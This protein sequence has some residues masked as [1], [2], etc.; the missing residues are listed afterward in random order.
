MKT[1]LLLFAFTV[2]L[3]SLRA[4]GDAPAVPQYAITDL[5]LLQAPKYGSVEMGA[6]ALNDA[7][8]VVG[9]D[10]H[11]FLWSG[12]KRTDLG[13]L[14]KEGTEDFAYSV[15]RGI[16]SHGQV[17]GSSG[18]FGPIVMSGLQF[19]RGIL[20]GNGRLRQLTQRNSSFEPYAINDRGLIVGLDGYR[21]FLYKNGRLIPLGTLSNVPAGNRSTARAINNS[22]QVVG[23]STVN[24]GMFGAPY[25]EVGRLVKRQG[26]WVE[27]TVRRVPTRT[28]F[29]HACLWRV[30]GKS[31]RQR[32]LGTLPGW[33]NSYAYGINDRG[34]VAGS[35]S[36]ATGRPYGVDTDL[37]DTGGRAEAFLWRGGR[38]TGLGTLPG[39]RSSEAHGINNAG[40]VVGQSDNRAFLWQGR[41]MQDLNA[42]L[43]AASGW[44]L[45]EAQAINSRGQIAGSGM[46]DGQRHA[47]LLTPR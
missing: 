40:A 7:G 24:R 31:V 32:D 30:I 3:L 11:A 33:V 23:W 46:R 14:P 38:M 18:S 4:V 25:V 41:K 35:I 15:A 10:S 1:K 19:A 12:G 43:P 36:D 45:E 26:K 47:F 29:T 27:E 2:A 13:A 37:A 5:G 44:T 22:A 42:L 39:S 6:F 9:G 21:G 16:N 17:V 20:Y 28:F 8:Q 34:E